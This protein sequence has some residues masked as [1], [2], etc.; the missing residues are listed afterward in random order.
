MFQNA[1]KPLIYVCMGIAACI[2]FWHLMVRWKT[3]Y[4]QELFSTEALFMALVYF[5]EDNDGAFPPSK[6]EFLVSGVVERLPDGR[7]RVLGRLDSVGFPSQRDEFIQA[8]DAFAIGWGVNLEECRLVRNEIVTDADGNEVW[9]I[10]V[11]GSPAS[12][13]AYTRGVLEVSQRVRARACPHSVE[14]Q[15]DGK[16]DV[17]SP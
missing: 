15:R 6:E 5:V 17:P 3:Q 13:R 12:S 11:P 10:N 14:T 4:K 16:Q 9:L 1:H 7:L 8:F 2:V